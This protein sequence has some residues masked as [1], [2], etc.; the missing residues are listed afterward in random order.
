MV[1]R[2]PNLWCLGQFKSDVITIFRWVI[3]Y[4]LIEKFVF[5]CGADGAFPW[6]ILWEIHLCSLRSCS[7]VFIALHE[8]R[9]FL[10]PLSVCSLSC[11]FVPSLFFSFSQSPPAS[12]PS[13]L[14]RFSA[15][16]PTKIRQL[17]QTKSAKFPIW[18][19]L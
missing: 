11:H 5:I 3:A 10:Y 14:F 6:F 9:L 13:E 4:W 8:S 17:Y 7:G 1:E 16:D 18:N 19:K 2:I 12:W 15:S